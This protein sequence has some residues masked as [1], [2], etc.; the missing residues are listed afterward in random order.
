MSLWRQRKQIERAIAGQLSPADEQRLRAHV[1]G[2]VE[3]RRHYDLLATQA[4]IL[5][6]DADGS[7]AANERE[8]GRLLSALPGAKP[9]R[10][11]PRGWIPAAAFA[12]AIGLLFLVVVALPRHPADDG[13]DSVVWRGA[14][15]AGSAPATF[16][17]LMYAAPLDG[18]ALEQKAN[19]PL[20]ALS[21]IRKEQWV[22]F[23]PREASHK[24]G[25]FRAVLIDANGKV[26]VLE[27]GH[28]VSLDPGRWRVFGVEAT[29]L[30]SVSLE[31]SFGKLPADAKRLPVEEGAQ[32]YGEL[33]VE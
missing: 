6:G 1:A 21:R 29:R 31:R 27:S 15:D 28:S 13:A 19:F 16:E 22:A 17:L 23:A 32:S 14:A 5:S 33:L 24:F 3:C 20:D 12:G 9:A 8:L 4:R 18:G 10:E 26:V 25:A 2:C 7:K 30:G 11:R